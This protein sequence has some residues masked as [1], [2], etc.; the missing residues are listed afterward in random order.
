MVGLHA[1]SGVETGYTVVY[2]EWDGD[3]D[4][5]FVKFT[6]DG[7]HYMAIEDPEDGYRSR[8]KDLIVSDEPPKYSFPPQV[9]DCFMKQDDDGYGSNILIMQDSVT[10]ENVLEVGTGDCNDY[11]PYCHFVY[12]PEGMACNNPEISE[13]SFKLI[14][15]TRQEL[16]S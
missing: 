11:Y 8:C 4:C 15:G 6:L 9:M 3:L 16:L 13:D 12:R 2:D 7:I 5:S 1:L 10:G 14:I